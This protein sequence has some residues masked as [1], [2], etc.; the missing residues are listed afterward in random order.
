MQLQIVDDSHIQLL[1]DDLDKLETLGAPFG[2]IQ[3]LA[4]SLAL[5]TTAVLREYATVGQF[6]LMPFAVD[7][8]WDYAERPRRIGAI[9]LRLLLRP[10]VPPSRHRALVR[11]AGRCTVHNTLTHVTPIETTLEVVG[12]EQA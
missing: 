3:M 1:V 10:H 12:A 2:A 5:C 6:K 4:A 8:R 9:Q 11:V 7:V